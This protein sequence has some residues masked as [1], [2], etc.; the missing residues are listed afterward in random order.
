M[1]TSTALGRSNRRADV[2]KGVEALLGVIL[3]AGGVPVALVRWVGSPLPSEVPSLSQVTE[4]L[5]DAY[6]PDEFLV[7]AMAMVCWL[8]WAQLVVSL[9]LETIAYVRGRRAGVVPLAG[10]VQRAAARMVATIALLGVL[11]STRGATGTGGATSGTALGTVPPARVTLVADQASGPTDVVAPPD[12]AATAGAPTVECTVQWRDTLWDLA[13]RH[14][15]D[16]L[17]WPEIFQLNDGRLQPDGGCLTDADHLEPGWR[18]LLPADARVADIASAEGG[19]ELGATPVSSTP[20]GDVA[21]LGMATADAG[22]VLLGE[23]DDDVPERS[24]PFDDVAVPVAED[25]PTEPAGPDAPPASAAPVVV[26]AEVTVAPGDSFWTL[27]EEQLTAAWGRTP[28]VE[29]IVP[30]WQAM[31]A[32]NHTRLA[33]PG[34]PDLIRPGE[35]FAAPVTPAEPGSTQA[36][37][38]LRP[39]APATT[40]DDADCDDPAPDGTAE[41]GAVGGVGSDDGTAEDGTQEGADET[42]GSAVPP[43]SDA[44]G[45]DPG[46]PGGSD[47]TPPTTPGADRGPGST[48]TPEHAASVED[49]DERDAVPVGLVGGGVA[50]AGAL[51]L[52]ERRRRA[53]QRHRHRGRV[54]PLPAPDLRS[55]ERQ[56]RWGADI[57]GSRALDVAL[58]TAA[59]GAGA[60]GLPLLRWAELAPGSATLVLAEPSSPPPGFVAVA[61][62]RWMTAPGLEHLAAA[63]SHAASPAPALVPVGTI[64]E[65]SELLVDLESSGVVALRGAPDD[66]LGLLRAIVVAAATSL[67]SDQTRIVQ[68]GLEPELDRLP[69]V[70]AASTWQ[71]ALDLAEAHGDRTEAALR[72]LRCPSLAQARAVGATPEAW[73]PLVV[74][75]AVPARDADDRRRIEELARRRN[76]AVGVVTVPSLD[77]R[78]RGR[79][80]TIGAHGWLQ[81]EDVDEPV[82]P[83]FLASGDVTLLV[84]LLDDARSRRDAPDDPA[85]VDLAPRRPVPP[86][87]PAPVVSGRDDGIESATGA[88]TEPATA[89]G[90]ATGRLRL[91]ELMDGVDVLVRVLGE[92]EAVRPAADG[93]PEEKLVPTRQRALE[94][95]SYLA[96]REAAVDRED[97]EISLFPDGANASKTVYNTVSSARSLLGDDLFPPPQGGRY[98]LSPAVMTDYGLLCELVAE[99]DDTEDAR[100]A[101]ELL[102]QALSLVRGEPFTGVGRGY[103][104]VGPH[105]GMIVTQVVDAA[106]ELAEVRLATGDWRSAEWAARQGLRAFPSDER[107]YRLLMRTARAAGNVPGVQRVFRELCAVLADPDVGVEPEDTLHPET[108]ELLEELTASTSRQGR[109]GA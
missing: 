6:I 57:P 46:G 45:E 50:V 42:A 10:G 18:L 64:E 95:I 71:A 104:W 28:G 73:D 63:A 20:P 25:E 62:D 98:E 66:V 83:R 103:A 80:L 1:S 101:A 89:P 74:V 102:A 5:R 99:A 106:E 31:V 21:E 72:S 79:A 60:T 4:A 29:E 11:L 22:M 26:S 92:V 84:D 8:V 76:T 52:L 33:P 2:L 55:G 37:A 30:Y 34:D 93:R 51:A 36:L 109:I 86:P 65:G 41:D 88:P 100:A 82:R 75:S 53:Q 68:I 47:G 49:A 12:A 69:G 39:P 40:P 54:V 91:A 35:V 17:R 48:A 85:V 96:L 70:A 38:P 105:R 3:L 58:R 13:E 15:G 87:P 16:P 32:Q 107:M 67:W 14:L 7:K 56:L 61:G 9:V 59:A 27:A 97:L 78:P 94:A 23:E 19:A 24:I 44:G 90:S 77:D 43:A 81:I 108:I